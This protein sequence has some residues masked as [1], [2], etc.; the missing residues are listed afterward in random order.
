MSSE[1][2][3]HA[4]AP[5]GAGAVKRVG[6]VGCGVMGSAIAELCARRGVEV[7]VRV[8][9]AESARRG[10]EHIDALLR[11][12]ARREKLD[13]DDVAAARGR[14]AICLS[15]D[16]LRDCD[17]IIEAVP[18]EEDVK[19]AVFAELARV[20]DGSQAVL[21]SNTSSLSITRLAAATSMP[22]RVLGLH[23]FNPV[24]S[25]PLVEVVHGERTDD[26]VCRSPRY[27]SPTCSAR[28][29]CGCPTARVS[30]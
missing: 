5:P 26:A 11:R 4:G 12:S 29:R 10:A 15:A 3:A 27:S 25:L 13:D 14:V 7:V 19:E 17:L 28:S 22:E 9:D 2:G 18:E 24:A 30:S 16:E 6:V 8:L 1:P 21:A 23:F 20:F